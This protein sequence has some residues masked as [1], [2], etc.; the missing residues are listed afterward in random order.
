MRLAAQQGTPR[1]VRRVEPLPGS[2][3]LQ[4][5]HVGLGLQWVGPTAVISVMISRDLRVSSRCLPC[6]CA[7]ACAY[8]CMPAVH[9]CLGEGQRRG[10]PLAA[11]RHG[12]HLVQVLRL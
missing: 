9:G 3:G 5:A 4:A 2:T 7:C 1:I 8:M 11:E 10:L 6:T 12:H